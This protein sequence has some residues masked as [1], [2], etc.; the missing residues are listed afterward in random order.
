MQKSNDSNSDFS[1]ADELISYVNE[2]I[3]GSEYRLTNRY[4]FDDTTISL[5][6]EKVLP[7]GGLDNYNTYSVYVDEKYNELVALIDVYKRQGLHRLSK[8]SGG[9]TMISCRK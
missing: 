1:S 2:Q 7:S 5:R 6:Y 9:H 4:N 3:I 8:N